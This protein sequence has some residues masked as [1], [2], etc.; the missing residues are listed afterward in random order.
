ME[1]VIK[2]ETNCLQ[3]LMEYPFNQFFINFVCYI[4][5][6]LFFYFDIFSKD[7]ENKIISTQKQLKNNND[8]FLDFEAKLEP[9]I[10]ILRDMC[11]TVSDEFNKF[12]RNIILRFVYDLN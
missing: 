6:S 1:I 7:H 3:I 5:D 2:K 4:R 9:L 8:H 12:I 10:S 11:H